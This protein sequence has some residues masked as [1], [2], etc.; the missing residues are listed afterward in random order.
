MLTKRL[1][2]FINGPQLTKIQKRKA[3]RFIPEIK[4]ADKAFKSA[5]RDYFAHP[6][7]NIDDDFSDFYGG[8]GSWTITDLRYA[9]AS[10]ELQK[11]KDKAIAFLVDCTDYKK[12]K[13]V[14]ISDVKDLRRC[15]KQKVQA[16]EYS[17]KPENKLTRF[18]KEM[19][20]KFKYPNLVNLVKNEKV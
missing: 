9:V 8:Y 12:E 7:C 4:K 13:R 5:Q 19:T 3:E 6:R 15:S 18:F 14:R 20:F 11:T 1:L 16:P 2:G 10:S 17:K